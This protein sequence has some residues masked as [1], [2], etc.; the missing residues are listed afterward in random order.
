MGYFSNIW[1]AIRG[2][3]VTRLDSSLTKHISN[4]F[5]FFQY[6]NDILW[7][8]DETPLQYKQAYDLC[9]PLSAVINHKAKAYADG[10]VQIINPNTGKFVRGENKAWENLMK[11][12]NPIQSGRQFF[13]QLHAFVSIN[14]YAVVLK[15]YPEGF[16]DVPSKLWVLP[17][18]CIEVDKKNQPL[19][20]TSESE[21]KQGF[22]FNCNGIRTKL[23]PENIILITDDNGDIDEDTW[24]PN[25]KIRLLSYPITTLISAAE[26]ETSMLQHRGALGM[27]TNAASDA[28]G[29]QPIDPQEE[30]ELQKKLSNYGL[31]RS[32][33]KYIITNAALR[34]QST[35]FPTRELMAHESYYKG[36]QDICNEYDFP[37]ELTPYSERKNLANVDSFDTILYQN[38]II[39]EARAIDEQLTL[40][41]NPKAVEIRHDYSD[42]PALQPDEKKRGD[43]MY[44][45]YRA[46]QVLW[47][48]SMLTRND[49]RE[50]I[51]LPRVSNPRF[52]LYK[53]ELTPE[54]QG[55]LSL[56]N[57]VMG[58]DNNDKKASDVKPD[59]EKLP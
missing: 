3:R 24:L 29:H 40:Q 22:W 30:E 6:Q 48:N 32:Q 18:W 2:E 14:G 45:I 53:N 7:R 46:N 13:K 41:L 10:E 44:S 12:P 4:S 54:E 37:Y 50:R 26:A 15:M 19:H 43:A 5:D 34:W 33:Y 35:T 23:N 21:L 28:A 8:K 17:Y 11:K 27:F 38:A 39:P 31:S 1:D 47:E 59:N 20:L 51:G 56:M 57:P 49:W 42:L 58:N 16:S 55:A 25:S 36:V 9:A 52:D